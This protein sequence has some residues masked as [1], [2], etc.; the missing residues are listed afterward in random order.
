VPQTIEAIALAVE[1][2]LEIPIVYNTSGY[3]SPDSIRRLDGL[4]DI[5]MPDFKLWSAQHCARYLGA[6]DY[7][8]IARE[9]IAMMHE[10]VG[11]LRLTPDGLACRGLL[12]RHLVMPGL[13]HETASIFDWLARSISPD[14]FVNVM[15]QYHPEHLVGR[16]HG[17]GTRYSSIDRRLALE[18]IEEAY[19]L[20]RR[21]GLWR[22]D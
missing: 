11:D 5:Y 21:A 4:I 6:K 18:E 22:F 15:G 16:P 20:A 1:A 12:I 13:L 17:Q 3:D 8:H 14:T 19:R 9:V 7:G 2:G 10:Q